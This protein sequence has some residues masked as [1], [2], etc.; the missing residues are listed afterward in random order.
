ED[1]E[2]LLIAEIDLGMIGVAKNAM[3]PVGH[4]A[5]P[6]VHRLLFNNKPSKPVEYFSLPLDI[7]EPPAPTD[8]Q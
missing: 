6:D 8:L 5:R 2:G 3:D 1:A 4:Y 7:A